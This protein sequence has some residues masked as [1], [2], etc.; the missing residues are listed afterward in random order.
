MHIKIIIN[1]CNVSPIHVFHQFMFTN[2]FPIKPHCSTNTFPMDCYGYW[3]CSNVLYSNLDREINARIKSFYSYGCYEWNHYVRNNSLSCINRL[4][5]CLTYLNWYNFHPQKVIPRPLILIL[6]HKDKKTHSIKIVS[7]YLFCI[8]SN[9]FFF[10]IKTKF[11][12]F[13]LKKWT[14]KKRNI[15]LIVS[16]KLGKN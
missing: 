13:S 1:V 14:L 5:W 7:I 15:L 11:W 12:L 16:Y 10:Y 6:I 3:R 4:C 2:V 8:K 9:D